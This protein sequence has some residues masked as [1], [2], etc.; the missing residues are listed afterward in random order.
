MRSMF[1]SLALRLATACFS[2]CEDLMEPDGGPFVYVNGS[3]A[4]GPV[5][6][7]GNAQ[8]GAQARIATGPRG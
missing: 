4:A 1:F 5:I 7:T 3:P 2:G 8:P 6:T